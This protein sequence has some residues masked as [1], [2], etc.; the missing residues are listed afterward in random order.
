MTPRKPEGEAART[1]PPQV[2][3]VAFMMKAPEPW[4]LS[5][6]AALAA[7]GGHDVRARKFASLFAATLMAIAPMHAFAQDVDDSVS[8]RERPRPEYDPLGLRFGGFDL[9]A[10]LDLSV[11]TTDNLFAE[12]IGADDDIIF[13]V[14]PSARLSSHWSRHALSFEGGA[15]FDSHE[16]FSSEDAET[17]YLRASGR[18]D[19]GGSS[20]ISAS[21]G[22]AHEVEP[23]TDPASPAT[24]DPVEYDV[25]DLA[26]TGRTTFNRFR[27]TGTVGRVEYEFDD[28]T[29]A[30]R[31]NDIAYLRGRLEVE[32]SPRI[33]LMLQAETDERDYDNAPV[34]N[35]DGQTYLVGATINF[36][37]LMRGEIAVGHFERDYDFGGSTDGLAVAGNLEWYVTRLT[38]LSFNAHRNS[39]DVIGGAVALPY[40]D[41]SYGGRVDH[42]LLRNLILTAGVQMGQ[43][44]YELISTEE[45]YFYGDIGADYLVNRRIVI[46]ARY[47]HNEV[48]SDLPLNSYDENRFTLGVSFRL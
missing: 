23:R 15:T 43:R 28:A 6:F 14:S 11:T 42:E 3:H 12:E 34:F 31:D 35:S 48:D 9:N 36:T 19:V 16:D 45:D 29:Q 18:L 22:W 1:F 24:P 37:D 5:A 25:T 39:E 4:R 38:T 21:A 32:V 44:E 41:S 20:S 2:Q 40:V 13:A 47:G 10:T 17:G 26:V 33:G 8:V 30:F 7:P 27:L 46:R